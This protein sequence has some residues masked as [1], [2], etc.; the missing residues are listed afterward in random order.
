MG[1]ASGSIQGRER[2]EEIALMRATCNELSTNETRLHSLG[3]RLR[4]C[5]KSGDAAKLS[6][7]G[8]GLPVVLGRKSRSPG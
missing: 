3:P 8:S 5:G 4:I 2:S 6:G 7:G 1:V